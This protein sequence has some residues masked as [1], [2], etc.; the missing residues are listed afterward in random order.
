MGHTR[1]SDDG[2][3]IVDEGQVI[4]ENAAIHAYC[5]KGHTQG[6]MASAVEQRHVAPICEII[7]AAV[8]WASDD[9]NHPDTPREEWQEVI[10]I[11]KAAPLLLAAAKE[12]LGNAEDADATGP[13]NVDPDEDYP[14]DENGKPWFGD[15]WR[16]REAIEAANVI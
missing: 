11:L 6:E 14:I 10:P 2:Q 7:E 12:V 16:L 1:L 4:A 13:E 15:Y 5:A 8:A 9:P 3:E